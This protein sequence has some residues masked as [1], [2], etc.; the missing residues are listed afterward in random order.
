[1]DRKRGK[2]ADEIGKQMGAK[3]DGT[4]SKRAAKKR[5]RTKAPNYWGIQEDK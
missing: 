5:K 4:G 2:R 1:M 3:L